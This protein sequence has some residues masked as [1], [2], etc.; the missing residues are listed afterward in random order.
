MVRAA[1]GHS[2]G[3][4]RGLGCICEQCEWA[5]RDPR[6]LGSLPSGS[7]MSWAWRRRVSTAQDPGS[8]SGQTACTQ[9]AVSDCC[10][11]NR[12]R[13]CHP[14]GPGGAPSSRQ[15]RHGA[16]AVGAAPEATS[17]LPGQSGPGKMA[18]WAPL[19]HQAS[20]GGHSTL[21]EDILVSPWGWLRVGH[22]SPV[23]GLTI[24]S[25]GRVGA[26]GGTGLGH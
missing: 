7:N 13:L 2:P 18:L 4:A 10:A 11:R 6:R 23:D 20:K 22:Q 12:Q 8:I 26:K 5:P 16:G 14:L 17:D 1:T 25:L 24:Q 3:P 21:A 19:P 9:P 15:W